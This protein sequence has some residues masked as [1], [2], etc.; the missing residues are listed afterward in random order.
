MYCD[1]FYVLTVYVYGPSIE[2]LSI[3]VIT[4]DLSLVHVLLLP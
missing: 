2:L 3:Y 1:L 4:D